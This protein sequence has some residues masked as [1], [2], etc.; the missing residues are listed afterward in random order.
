[1]ILLIKFDAPNNRQNDSNGQEEE[2]CHKDTAV[3]LL[4]GLAELTRAV[5]GISLVLG[6]THR[7]KGKHDVP[8]NEADADEGTLAADEEHSRKEGH[9]HPRDEEG[10]CQDLKIDRHAIREEALCPNH[11]KADQDFN[12][13]T[14][15]IFYELDLIFLFHCK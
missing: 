1:M 10:V 8:E 4:F 9:Q 2:S 3:L 14:N 11:K 5:V 12:S 7:D 15:S 6:S 13:K